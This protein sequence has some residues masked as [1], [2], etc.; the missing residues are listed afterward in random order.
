M[1]DEGVAEKVYEAGLELINPGGDPETLRNAADAWKALG[2]AL[3]G[4]T[5][6]MDAKVRATVGTEWR[7]DSADAFRAHW[8]EVKKSIEDAQ[9]TFDE[10]SKGLNHA[11]DNIESINEEIH[12][13]YLEIGISIGVSIG[14]SFL[15]M[16]FSA[17]AGAANAARLA[18]EAASAAVKLG[19]ILA[20]IAQWFTRLK[21]GAVGAK[22]LYYGGRAGMAYGKEFVSGVA[23]S[24]FSGNGVQLENNAIGAGTA[25]LGGVGA[26]ALL[27]NR[28]G[29]GVGEEMA[30]G[31]LGGFTGTVA[32][33]AANAYGPWA[34]KGDEFDWSQSLIG[35]S[36]SA[37]GGAA[38]VGASSHIGA[39]G[40]SAA[41]GESSS[42]GSAPSESGGASGDAPINAGSN[43]SPAGANSPNEAS[44]NDD[45][46]QHFDAA[47]REVTNRRVG[48]EYGV[49][50]E[51]VK[52]GDQDGD[53]VI[54][55]QEKA[56]E[57]LRADRSNTK[58]ASDFG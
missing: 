43:E 54:A 10:A 56:A 11:A 12:Q 32:G 40:V 39:D 24:S 27:R 51:Q 44:G 28:L 48:T 13:I 42:Q 34:D 58:L 26:G 46:K 3:D 57:K 35:A 55:S 20:Q 33:D 21:E 9:S 36:A 50:G 52:Q 30:A 14:M 53:S 16:G 47:H 17:A 2:S 7:G 31:A 19:R 5:V 18:E 25:A 29:G 23:T 45:G 41:S 1:A 4:F 15:T 37:A 38:G 49:W 6:R 8:G 22:V